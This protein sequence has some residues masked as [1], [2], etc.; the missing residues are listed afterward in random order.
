MHRV[1]PLHPTPAMTKHIRYTTVLCVYHVAVVYPVCVAETFRGYGVRGQHIGHG[2]GVTHAADDFTDT[3]HALCGQCARGRITCPRHWLRAGCATV[4]IMPS[5]STYGGRRAVRK[6]LART[7]RFHD[8]G[9]GLCGPQ[10]PALR[11]QYTT[12]SLRTSHAHYTYRPCT[13]CPRYVR[14]MSVKLT[15]VR[16]HHVRTHD[17]IHGRKV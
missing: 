4:H 1:S 10:R 9:R 12:I 6:D 3:V 15:S 11:T 14:T 17:A 16:R 5:L 13:P 2:T 7:M 8:A